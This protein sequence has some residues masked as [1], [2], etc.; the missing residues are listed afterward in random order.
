MESLPDAEGD[1]DEQ[2]E[3]E[4][5]TDEDIA[6]RLLGLDVSSISTLGVGRL[7][8]VGVEKMDIVLNRQQVA[9]SAWRSV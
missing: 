9:V 7:S 2:P 5:T 4:R 3:S 8:D 1:I 6:L